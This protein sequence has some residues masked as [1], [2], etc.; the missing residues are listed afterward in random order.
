LKADLVVSLN[1]KHKAAIAL[2][3]QSLQLNSKGKPAGAGLTI[4]VVLRNHMIA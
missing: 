3:Q 4:Y 1:L 2:S